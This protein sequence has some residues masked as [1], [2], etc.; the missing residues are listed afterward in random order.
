MF[1]MYFFLVSILNLVN[2]SWRY[3]IFYFFHR[4]RPK[5]TDNISNNIQRIIINLRA[6]QGRNIED[7]YNIYDL[8][9]LNNDMNYF[10]KTL[11]NYRK[12]RKM[13][14][15]NN[16]VSIVNRKGVNL[17]LEVDNTSDDSSD[18]SCENLRDGNEAHHTR[19]VSSL[20]DTDFSS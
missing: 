15:F 12:K 7:N 17:T 14:T 13:I 10:I 20:K 19:I 16:E 9:R 11:D 1:N 8:Y 6:L 18:D 2:N 4:D 5:I 3:I